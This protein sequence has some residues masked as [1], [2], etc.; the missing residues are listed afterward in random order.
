MATHYDVLGVPRS[1]SA[2]TIRRAY[3]RQARA[4][5][6]DRFAGQ[7]PDDAARAENTMRRI[8][9]AFRILGDRDRRRDYDRQLAGAPAVE[10]GVSVRDGV[11][12]VDPR[13]LD[14][15]YLTARRH[16]QEAVISTS[17][18]RMMNLVP[19]VGF[20]C[21]LAAIFIFTAYATRS[22]GPAE[23]EVPG[24]DI[25]VRANAC[26]RIIQGPTLL[27][28][29]CDRI[30]DGRVI[31]A[32]LPEGSCPALTVREISLDADTIVCLG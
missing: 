7:P 21:L 12:R 25:G 6:P 10:G 22:D 2:E 5:H 1:A 31:G 17:H 13:L 19:W 24:P 23:I 3:H 20:L 18:S 29:P 9:E 8:N 32:R 11:T 27:E 16:R 26:V 14:P 15:D 30:N 4:W 28:V